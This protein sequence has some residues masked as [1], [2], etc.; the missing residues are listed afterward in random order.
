MEA[1]VIWGRRFAVFWRSSHRPWLCAIHI[2]GFV[3]IF[4]LLLYQLIYLHMPW[5]AALL[6]VS[7][8]IQYIVSIRYHWLPYDY[9]R[10]RIDRMMIAVVVTMTAMPYWLTQFS[11]DEIWWRLVG[12]AALTAGTCWLV[13]KHNN[14]RKGFIAVGYLSIGLYGIV[15]SWSYIPVWLSPASYQLFWYGVICYLIQHAFL[16]SKWPKRDELY[17]IPQHVWL[18]P[19]CSLHVWILPDLWLRFMQP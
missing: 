5:Q 10:A 14:E 7:M 15:V 17:R 11:F 2:V 19:A 12:L 4:T 3:T 16:L 8:L 1:I 18:I 9:T 13:W 6:P